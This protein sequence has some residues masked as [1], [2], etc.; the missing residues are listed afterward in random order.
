MIMLNMLT[1]FFFFPKYNIVCFLFQMNL[2]LIFWIGLISS[3]CCVFGQAGKKKVAYLSV[4][5]LVSLFDHFRFLGKPKSRSPAPS[6]GLAVAHLSESRAG[7]FG[8]CKVLCQ[9]PHPPPRETTG[10]E[11][12][13][14]RPL[15]DIIECVS[16]HRES[17]G[18]L[19]LRRK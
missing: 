19:H 15:G 6:E 16:E 12:T 11:G 3:V 4:Q 8:A 2:Q 1:F 14:Q 5:Y 10:I 13:T 7:A 18:V 9:V 17:K